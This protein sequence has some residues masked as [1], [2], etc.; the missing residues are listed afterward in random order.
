MSL[1]PSSPSSKP[2][3]VRS[4]GGIFDRTSGE[5]APSFVD[6]DNILAEH[7][8]SH[9]E[10][11]QLKAGQKIGVLIEYSC[12]CWSQEFPGG[13]PPP[14]LLIRDGKKVRAVNLHRYLDSL[15]LPSLLRNL[16]SNRVF[17][18]PS[19]RNYRTYCSSWKAGNGD[20]YS[21]FFTLKPFKGRHDSKRHKLRLF[22]E[23]AYR[24]PVDADASKTSFVAAASAALQNRMIKRRPR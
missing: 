18:A 8:T 3:V 4:C 2:F 12:H 5:V 24:R 10:Y 23:S 1:P 17:V 19:D 13:G 20:P 15:T 22:V 9:V 21:A 11:F 16:P 7:L 14:G 6:A